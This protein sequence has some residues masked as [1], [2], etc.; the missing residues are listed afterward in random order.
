MEWILGASLTLVCGLLWQRF[1]RISVIVYDYEAGLLYRDG[2]VQKHC[3]AGRYR[4]HPQRQRLD[5]VDL[6][7]SSVTI[8]AQSILTADQAQI[9]VTLICEYQV[10]DAQKYLHEVN[11]A[12][13]QLYLQMQL[14]LRSALQR[15]TLDE[16]I[17]GEQ[18][19]LDELLGLGQKSMQT[20]G[21]E[22]LEVK[23]KDLMLPADLRKAYAEILSIQKRHEARMEQARSE[24]ASLRKLANAARQ[25]AG[26]PYLM[27]LRILQSIEQSQVA[28]SIHFP[29]LPPAQERPTPLPPESE[30]AQ[31]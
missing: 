11:N 18:S 22:L 3:S 14:A 9:K 10:Q 26:N 15:Q 29:E 20:L 8:P 6:R 4:I 19:L 28:H 27:H 1:K 7:R 21:I 25:I 17:Q 31:S 5:K 2:Q 12:E 16:L 30:G 24:Q 23:I 13:Q